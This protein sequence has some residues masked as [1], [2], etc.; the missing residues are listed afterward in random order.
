MFAASNY[1]GHHC[2]IRVVWFPDVNHIEH[3]VERGVMAAAGLAQVNGKATFLSRLP[4]GPS[5]D[6]GHWFGQM[7]FAFQARRSV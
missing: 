7:K 5:R 6:A 4:Y 1:L 3:N 2:G